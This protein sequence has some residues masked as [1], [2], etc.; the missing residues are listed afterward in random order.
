MQTLFMPNAAHAQNENQQ[1]QLISRSM[2]CTQEAAQQMHGGMGFIGGLR[3]FFSLL[4]E[5]GS[6]EMPRISFACVCPGWQ[7]NLQ[8]GTAKGPA[9]SQSLKCKLWQTKVAF[10]LLS[11]ASPGRAE[12]TLAP[13]S[14]PARLSERN[15]CREQG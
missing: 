5:P 15:T 4:P 14:A 11:A 3:I 13:G 2:F 8:A 1:L 12:I 6:C 9:A 7:E 10:H